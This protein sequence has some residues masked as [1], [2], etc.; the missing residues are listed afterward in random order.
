MKSTQALPTPITRSRRPADRY[1]HFKLTRYLLRVTRDPRY[2][3]SMERMMYN[4]ILGALPLQR[5]G[6]S[7]ITRITTFKAA[8]YTATIAGPAVPALIPKSLQITE[9]ILICE[10]RREFLWRCIFP[11]RRPGNRMGLR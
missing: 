6:R 11:L 3:D 8:R 4:T 10:I 9:S 2:G 5:D 1:A 7:S